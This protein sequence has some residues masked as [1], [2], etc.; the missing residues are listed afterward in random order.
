[1]CVVLQLL[2]GLGAEVHRSVFL[3]RLRTPVQRYRK[4]DKLGNQSETSGAK[5]YT[6]ARQK[7]KET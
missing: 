6:A 2:R 5:R 4:V 3:A 7:F 1:M